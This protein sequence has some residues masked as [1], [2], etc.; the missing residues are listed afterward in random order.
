M[1]GIL[2]KVLGSRTSHIAQTDTRYGNEGHSSLLIWFILFSFFPTSVRHQHML[3]GV[4][5]VISNHRAALSPA[6]ALIHGLI[7][8][9]RPRETRA[10]QWTS[11]ERTHRL[12]E[13]SCSWHGTLSESE[14]RQSEL[15]LLI[16]WQG[17]TESWPLHLG[18]IMWSLL[19]G[20]LKVMRGQK[21]SRGVVLPDC[22]LEQLRALSMLC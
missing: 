12:N 2:T 3:C 15:F 5:G 19:A 7:K 17:F 13:F 10:H 8:K 6:L 21:D 20:P 9:Q 11:D 14:I 18:S 4:L 22:I 1:S 16:S